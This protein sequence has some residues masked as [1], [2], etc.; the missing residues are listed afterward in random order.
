MRPVMT[1]YGGRLHALG[2]SLDGYL[3]LFR[4]T[5]QQVAAHQLASPRI[6]TSTGPST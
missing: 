2:R 6:K 5:L 4:S 3:V 1:I